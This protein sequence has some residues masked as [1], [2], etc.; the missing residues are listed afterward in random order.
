VRQRHEEII[1]DDI[2]DRVTISNFAFRGASTFWAYEKARDQ[3]RKWL[4]YR[5]LIWLRGPRNDLYPNANRNGGGGPNSP[6]Q[7]GVNRPRLAR[8]ALEAASIA[9]TISSGVVAFIDCQL[10]ARKRA[11]PCRIFE[12]D[13]ASV[14]RGS[15]SAAI[16]RAS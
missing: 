4:I 5:G 6:P 9:G 1:E 2:L 8:P 15:D 3:R 13:W 11:A 7:R 14:M 12:I 10:N 16:W